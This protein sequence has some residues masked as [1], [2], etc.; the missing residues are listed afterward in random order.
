MIDGQKKK[1]LIFEKINQG[2]LMNMHIV[3][4]P[5]ASILLIYFILFPFSFRDGKRADGELLVVLGM[6]SR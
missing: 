5:L 4:A 3:M 6:H 2:Q 1:K